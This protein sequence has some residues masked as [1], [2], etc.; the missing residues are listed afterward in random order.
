MDAN[1]NGAV[2]FSEFIDLMLRGDGM[3]EVEAEDLENTFQVFDH[4]GDG[5]ITKGE[6]LLTMSRLGEQ[7]TEDDI[8][9]MIREADLDGDGMINRREFSRLLAKIFGDNNDIFI[10]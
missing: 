2:D 4:N 10:F 5:F 3:A 6:L 9:A 1:R 8:Q 7:L